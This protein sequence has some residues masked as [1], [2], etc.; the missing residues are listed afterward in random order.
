MKELQSDTTT[1]IAWEE[2]GRRDPYYGVI[3]D[4]KFRR[5]RIDGRAKREFFESG[6]SHV[7]GV[8]TTIR[9]HIDPGFA[10]RRVLDFGCGVG[11][12][13][14]PFAKTA[15][16][17][18]GLDVSASMLQEAQRNCDEHGLSNVRLLSSDDL[19]SN[20]TGS[21]DLI[22]SCIVFQH[23]PAERGRSIFSKLLQRIRPGGVGAI[24]MTYSK[25][26]FGANHGLAPARPAP[27]PPS[28][29]PGKSIAADVDPEI[30]MNPYNMN[31][32]LF[33]MQRCGVQ[34]SHIEFSNHGG[35]LGVF[36]FFAV[37]G[38]PIVIDA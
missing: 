3:T 9:K 8:L 6:E 32:I 10:P 38:P 11:R 12:L 1:D 5:S 27:Q 7:H 19:L 20:L 15:E 23:I 2:W 13:L 29:A 25:A 21:F 36:L 4:P 33:S 17:A 28:D 37:T 24:H 30:Q 26:R 31:E 34:K 22:H 14:I 18:V 35:E 16:E